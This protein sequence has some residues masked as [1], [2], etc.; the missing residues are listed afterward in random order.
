[1]LSFST[2]ISASDSKQRETP[3][4]TS[5]VGVVACYSKMLLKQGK[6]MALTIQ[7]HTMNGWCQLSTSPE[8]SMFMCDFWMGN[9][10]WTERPL[11]WSL[12]DRSVWKWRRP[13]GDM[14][15]G[16]FCFYPHRL[17]LQ[18]I[19]AGIRNSFFLAST[20]T[21]SWLLVNFWAFSWGQAC[22]CGLMTT[23]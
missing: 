15:A 12:S 11:E 6:S 18:W 1:M 22:V 21:C 10:E 14:V 23:S 2:T 16:S 9:A 8:P 4:L 5:G 3:C 13:R 7:Y 19:R 17:N 20:S